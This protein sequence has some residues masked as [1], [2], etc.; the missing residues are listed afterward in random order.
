MTVIKKKK[1]NKN[2]QLESI[3]NNMPYLVYIKALDGKII[4][5]NSQTEKNNDIP[6]DFV[7]G[8]NFVDK[9]YPDK[10]ET[11]ENEDRQVVEMR[12]T[13]VFEKKLY[14]KK[15]EPPHWYQISKSPI[16]DTNGN[17]VNILLMIKNI[18]K[19]KSLEEQKETLIATITHDLKTPTCAQLGAMNYLLEEK[20]GLLNE[21]QKEYIQM[22]KDSNIYMNTMIS[23]IL[24]VFKSEQENLA[25]NPEMFNLYEL[26]QT[27]VKEITNLALTKKQDIIIQ[28]KLNNNKIIA[29]KLQLKR[30]ITNLLGNA[31]T[32][33]FESTNIILKILENED[34]ITFE[35]ENKGYYIPADKINEI[36]EKYKTSGN[37]LYNQASTGLGLYLAKKIINAHNGKIY[38]KSFKNQTCIFGFVV[39]RTFNMTLNEPSVQL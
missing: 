18:D 25:A 6:F 32:Y 26:V 37:T 30:V 23:T 22:A 28:S 7:V 35:V 36:F 14:H 38:A 29:D 24:S 21:Q 9:Y 17:V 19:E 34:N 5:L 20:L 3:L 31:I 27:A 1:S 15:D 39:P 13:F 11:I 4:F 10:A 2:A 33:G 12:K 8:E 16:F